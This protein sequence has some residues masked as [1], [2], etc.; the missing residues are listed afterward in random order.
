[1]SRIVVLAA[2]LAD[3][4]DAQLY[5][6]DRI[7]AVVT[8]RSPNRARGIVATH[9]ATTPAWDHLSDAS[10]VRALESTIPAI[11]CNHCRAEALKVLERIAAPIITSRPSPLTRAGQDHDRSNA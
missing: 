6:H 1:M 7:A 3:A 8:P 9:L 11:E 5:A 2:T 4:R 10:R